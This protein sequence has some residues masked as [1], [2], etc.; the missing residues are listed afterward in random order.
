[1]RLTMFTN[2]PAR[3]QMRPGR[4]NLWRPH[5]TNPD[6]T[7]PVPS[8]SPKQGF[9]LR[10]MYIHPIVLMMGVAIFIIAFDNGTFWQEGFEKFPEHPG[11]FAVLIGAVFFLF[12][13]IMSIFGG[14]WVVKPAMAFFLILSAVSSYYVDKL[15]VVIDRDMVQNVVTTTFNEGKHLI[16][17]SFVSHVVIFGVMPS[18]VV[19]WF[20]LR[21]GKFWKSVLVNVGVLV[22]GFALAVGLLLTNFKTYAS[23]FRQ[24]KDLMGSFQPGAPIVGTARYI[25]LIYRA[26]NIVVAPTGED[27]KKGPDIAGAPKPVLS[28]VVVGETARSQNFG[29]NGYERDTNAYTAKLPV[30]S[31]SD[32]NSCGTATAVSMP[33]MF[34]MYDRGSYSYTRG[35]S[36]EN[37]LDVLSRADVDVKWWDNNTGSKTIA[38]RVEYHT[39]AGTKN[40]EFCATGECD[41]G[42]FQ[43]QL[44]NY[45]NTITQDTVLVFHLIG[46]HG[47]TYYLRY[48]DEFEVFTPPCRTADFQYC[49]VQEVV[50]SYD[51]TILYTDYILA[52]MVDFL[53]S[54]DKVIPSLIYV[55]DHGESLGEGGLYLHG[56]PYMFAP[57]TQTKVGMQVWLSQAY[58][59]QF[60][61]DLSC[62][63][64]NKD[65]TISHANL[66]SSILGLMDIQTEVRQEDLDIFSKCKT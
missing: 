42:I 22:L 30:V 33:C 37:V 66:F 29:A 28:I 11:Q 13:A 44:V 7:N 58:Q 14:R 39:F 12:M 49:A 24:Q 8:E 3:T 18:L 6:T 9:L 26:K 38:D 31:F 23:I 51:N 25:K 54:Q 57:E 48:P 62:L 40:Q 50:N 19:F 55:S 61:V 36:T 53:S 1:M 46:S 60:G 65:D 35:I 15:G 17:I 32:V 56:A 34:S 41:D 47:P 16:T 52:Q 59:D 20:K 4:R 21:P 27:A 45:A 43:Q 64:K 2:G 63:E 10:R 5:M